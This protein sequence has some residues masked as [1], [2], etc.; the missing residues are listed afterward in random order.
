MLLGRSDM[1]I[2]CREENSRAVGW[3][4]LAIVVVV[5]VVVVVGRDSIFVRRLEWYNL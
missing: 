4:A 5:V 1:F 2:S 3:I